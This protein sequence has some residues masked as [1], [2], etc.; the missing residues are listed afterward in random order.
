M[1]EVAYLPSP[2]EACRT[3]LLAIV[4]ETRPTQTPLP[5]SRRRK[6]GCRDEED[7]RAYKKRSPLIKSTKLPF[8]LALLRATEFAQKLLIG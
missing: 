5:S 4:C 7:E 8:Q 1:S 2:N 6:Q 3:H